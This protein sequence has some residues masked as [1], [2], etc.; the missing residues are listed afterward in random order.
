MN[1]HRWMTSA[2]ALSLLAGGVASAP[3]T[4]FT[5]V[6]AVEADTTHSV[7]LNNTKTGVTYALHQI[8]GGRL[9]SVAIPNTTPTEYEEILTDIYFNGTSFNKDTLIEGLSEFKGSADSA[10]DV[11]N[12]A[13]THDVEFRAAALAALN[14]NAKP[15][16]DPQPG[17]DGKSIKFEGLKPG[18]YLVTETKKEKVDGVEK[19]VTRAFVM[20]AF[21][22]RTEAD[23]KNASEPQGDKHVHE[24]DDDAKNTMHKDKFPGESNT[25]NGEKDGYQDVADYDIGDTVPFIITANNLPTWKTIEDWNSHMIYMSDT[26][27]EAL[28]LQ[29]KTIEIKAKDAHGDPVNL[30]DAEYSQYVKLHVAPFGDYT[31]HKAGATFEVE[32]DFKGLQKALYDKDNTNG[33]AEIY[34]TFDAILNNKAVAGLPGADKNFNKYQLSYTND[35]NTGSI[36]DQEEDYTYVFTYDADFN[37]VDT[38]DAELEGAQFVFYKDEQYTNENNEV[39][40][41]RC[42]Y[43]WDAAGKVTGT[44]D[45]DLVDGKC[46]VPASGIGVWTSEKGKTFTLTGLDQGTYYLLETKAPEGYNKLAGPVEVVISSEK[47]DEQQAVSDNAGTIYNRVTYTKDGEAV[48]P[49]ENAGTPT[50]NVVNNKGAQLP[51]TGGMGTTMFYTAGGLIVAGAGL[52]LITSKRMKKEEE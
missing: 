8:Y 20:Q 18:L 14:K 27:S 25:A 23:L 29:E 6:L 10:E 50:I 19:D 22:I 3:A 30:R 11:L 4:M 12:Y 9:E 45:V 46:D 36:H 44:V 5:S 35:P 39:K 43:T 2:L 24:D 49:G 16:V 34:V 7:T 32:I 33:I 40:T 38:N 48:D 47:L 17:E 21:G 1:K 51:E 15:A 31:P 13:A 28:D 41:R 42:F 52:Y 37:K 26:M